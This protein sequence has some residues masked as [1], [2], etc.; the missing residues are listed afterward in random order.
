MWTATYE[1]AGS[2]PAE[3]LYG[4]HPKEARSHRLSK[5]NQEG[6]KKSN[7]ET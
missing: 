7:S 3:V 4:W 1:V 5:E 2:N 6:K